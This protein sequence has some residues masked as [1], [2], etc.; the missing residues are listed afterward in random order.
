MLCNEKVVLW[1]R[2]G[3][4]KARKPDEAAE[5]LTRWVAAASLS[6]IAM[7]HSAS[8]IAGIAR[9]SRSQGQ[10]RQQPSQAEKV[11]R[12][13]RCVDTSPPCLAKCPR[14]RT[15]AVLFWRRC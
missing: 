12:R 1:L 15:P 3:R 13:Y 6:A 9:Q 8:P 4:T 14:C 10:L 11:L 5:A 2:A 7:P